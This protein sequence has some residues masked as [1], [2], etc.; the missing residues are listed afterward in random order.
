[1]FSKYTRNLTYD[2]DYFGKHESNQE[3]SNYFWYAGFNN[4]GLVGQGGKEKKLIVL[5][6]Q[7]NPL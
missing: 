1:M 3:V 5:A 7:L 6:R 2:F 4:A